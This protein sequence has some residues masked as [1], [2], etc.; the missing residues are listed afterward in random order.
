MT[1]GSISL[2]GHDRAAFERAAHLRA[3]HGLKMVDAL[4]LA[5]ALQ[6]GAVCLISNDHKFPQL[7]EMECL[8]LTD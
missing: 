7:A 6:G 4:H 3:K 8:S 1:D 2:L 5:T